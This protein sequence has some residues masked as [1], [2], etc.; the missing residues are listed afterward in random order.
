MFHGFDY[1]DE[2]GKDE[3]HSRFWH[4]VMKQGILE[5][6]KPENCDIRRYVRKMKPKEFGLNTTLLPVEQEEVVQ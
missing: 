2:T 1:P 6:P 3:L 4:A 5:F